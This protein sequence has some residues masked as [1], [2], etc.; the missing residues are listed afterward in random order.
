MTTGDQVLV[1]NDGG[2]VSVKLGTD[3]EVTGD[4]IIN[5][6]KKKIIPSYELDIKGTWSGEHH[7]CLGSIWS[8]QVS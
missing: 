8:V 5:N 4:A 2:D 1:G 6:R 3:V 7:S